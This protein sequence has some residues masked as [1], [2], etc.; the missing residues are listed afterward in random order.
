[1]NSFFEDVV[2]PVAVIV[3]VCAAALAAIVAV[4]SA[5]TAYQCAQYETVTGKPTKFAGM[6]CYINDGG[7]W[8]AWSEYKNRLVTRGD[9]GA[10]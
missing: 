3:G 6:E 1:M 10:K 4:L 7:K 2:V 5:L 8:F 9:M